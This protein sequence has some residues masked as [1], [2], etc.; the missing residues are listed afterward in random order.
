MSL[1]VLL[2][3]AIGWPEEQIDGDAIVI[4]GERYPFDYNDPL[5]IEPIKEKYR[6]QVI[7]NGDT[8]WAHVPGSAM[9][10]GATENEAVA[11]AVIAAEGIV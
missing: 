1:N 7:P 6:P 2:A 11:K 8:F 10:V 9:R 3:R 4:D 5:V